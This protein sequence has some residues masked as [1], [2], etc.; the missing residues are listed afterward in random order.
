MPTEQEVGIRRIPAYTLHYTTGLTHLRDG[1]NQNL[2]WTEKAL[3]ELDERCR[4]DGP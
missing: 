3:Y 2:K 4:A 1:Q